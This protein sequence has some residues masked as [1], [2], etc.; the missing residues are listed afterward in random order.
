MGGWMAS[1]TDGWIFGWM[2]EWVGGLTDECIK[3]R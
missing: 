1:G 3:Y 2:V